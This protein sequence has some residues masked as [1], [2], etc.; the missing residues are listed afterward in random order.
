MV[1]KTSQPVSAT[2]AMKD[3]MEVAR[4]SLPDFV[5]MQMVITRVIELKPELDTLA[6]ATRWRNAW[7]LKVA[8]KEFTEAVES[9]AKHFND[10][11]KPA[12]KRLRK[13]K[14]HRPQQ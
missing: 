9:A 8:D 10:E 3:R 1:M 14:L 13:Q 5:G 11:Y 4:K 6:N 7:Q 2:Q 12:E